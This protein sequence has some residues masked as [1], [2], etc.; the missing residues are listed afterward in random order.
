MC[1]NSSCRVEERNSFRREETCSFFSDPGMVCHSSTLL[2]EI[3]MVINVMFDK[4]LHSSISLV[5]L[6]IIRSMLGRVADGASQDDSS[7][8]RAFARVLDTARR[9]RNCLISEPSG[10]SSESFARQKRRSFGHQPRQFCF[11]AD[12]SV[13]SS[14]PKWV[15]TRRDARLV[16][17]LGHRSEWFRW[18]PGM[19]GLSRWQ[20][21]QPSTEELEALN[22][23]S[24]FLA[25][26]CHRTSYDIHSFLQRRYQVLFLT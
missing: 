4:T 14:Y 9:S 25:R 6:S 26:L 22:V 1:S 21:C 17:I 12:R 8:S 3:R 13:Q 18:L 23:L 24:N 20:R 16:Q 11:A 2:L 5:R 10:A 19:R 7:R 15:D